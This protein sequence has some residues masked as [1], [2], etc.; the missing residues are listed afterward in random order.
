MKLGIAAGVMMMGMMFVIGVLV[1]ALT[2][3]KPAA[4]VAAAETKPDK[5]APTT[6]PA[7]RR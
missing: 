5:A 7:R 2:S 6:T 1:Y 4:A 3:S